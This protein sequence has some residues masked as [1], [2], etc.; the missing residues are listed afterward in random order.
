GSEIK[1]RRRAQAA[2]ADHQNEPRAP[3]HL[4]LAAE[5]R[6]PDLPAVALDFFARESRAHGRLDQKKPLLTHDKKR[7][8]KPRLIFAPDSRE[9]VLAP[10]IRMSDPFAVASKGLSLH[11]SG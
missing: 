10:A 6:H 5:V 9:R 2:G 3:A 4:P 7:H 8:R 1:R 11:H